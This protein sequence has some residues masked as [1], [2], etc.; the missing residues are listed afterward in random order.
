MKEFDLLVQ[1]ANNKDL[2]MS[3]LN[4]LPI[5]I[6]SQNG[7]NIRFDTFNHS[8]NAYS[9][10][11]NSLIYFNFRTNK[12]GNLIDLMQMLTDQPRDKICSGLY[13]T[14]LSRGLVV[15]YERIEYEEDEYILE[16]P[17]SYDEDLLLAYP[18]IFSDLFY[19]DNLDLITQYYWGIRYDYKSH[20]VLIPVYQDESLVGMIGR[21]NKNQ[22]EDSENK[23]FPILSYQKSAVLFGYD[24]YKELVKKTKTVILVESE[25][26]V[27]KAWQMESKLPVL[28]IGSSNVS[29]HHIERLNLLGVQRIILALDKGIEEKSVMTNDLSKISR[30]SNAKTIEYIDVDSCSRLKDK[31]CIFDRDKD[32]INHCFKEHLV[33]V[34]KNGKVV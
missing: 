12:S 15:P 27:M 14:L 2:V 5:K 16:I 9:M 6:T 32:I 24:E 11:L 7:D 4:S 26:S 30:Y 20:R 8:S 33:A 13:L 28:A 31:E 18:K 1:L 21:L 17:D 23:Y 34:R 25:K 22:I 19:Q 10:K 3:I 29:R